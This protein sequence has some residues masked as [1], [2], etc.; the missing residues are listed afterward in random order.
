MR[1]TGRTEQRGTAA[2]GM[3]MTNKDRKEFIAY[4]RA[5]TDSQVEG[6]YEKE[7]MARRFDYAQLAAE[8][9]ARRGIELAA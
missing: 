4:L 3:I 5:C 7:R 2:R 1:P 6:V 8:E 9:A